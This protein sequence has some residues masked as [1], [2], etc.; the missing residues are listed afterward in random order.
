MAPITQLGRE[1]LTTDKVCR[2]LRSVIGQHG[3]RRFVL[4][5]SFARG[6]QT[7]ESDVDV[8]V[9]GDFKER[10]LDRYLTVLPMLH[11]LLRPHAAEP[12]IY[13]LDEF[14]R[15]RSRAGG[16]VVTACK[17]GIEIDVDGKASV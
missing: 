3:I 1:T 4:F 16:I 2:R 5:G 17:E 13:T 7:A 10:F 14:E 11:E 12:L 9:I 15:L 8:I 6:T